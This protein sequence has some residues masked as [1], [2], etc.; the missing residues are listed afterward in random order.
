ML[1]RATPLATV[2]V[3]AR[4]GT[5]FGLTQ[6]YDANPALV[7]LHFGTIQIPPQHPTLLHG[8]V[9]PKKLSNSIPGF[10]RKS[11]RHET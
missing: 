10:Y 9:L 6:T 11:M 7:H 3:S 1:E 2:D 8:V 4:G 5:K